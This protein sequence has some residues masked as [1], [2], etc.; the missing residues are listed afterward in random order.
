MDARERLL[1]AMAGGKPDRVPVF[2]SAYWDYWVRSVGANLFDYAYGDLDVQVDIEVR[3]ARRH[4]GVGL[5]RTAGLNH[6]PAPPS[7]PRPAHLPQSGPPPWTELIESHLPHMVQWDEAPDDFVRDVADI[8]RVLAADH[9]SLNIGPDATHLRAVAGALHDDAVIACGGF[10]LFPHTRRALGGVERT[11]FALAENPGLVEATMDALLERYI[12]MIASAA[13]AGADAIWAGAYNE[14]GDMIS[15]RMWRRL[16]GP[17]HEQLVQIAH[18]AGLKAICWFLGDC[19][20][21]VEDLARVGYDMLVIEESRIGYR[22]DVGEMRRRVGTD[23][24]LS[25]WVPELAMLYDDRDAIARHVEE[26]YEA[27]GRDGA[28]IFSTSML[29]SSVDP[30]TVDFFCQKVLEC[31]T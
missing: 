19:L 25:G 4:A 6:I 5:H 22:S 17:R 2:V 11:M 7:P 21:L 3:A 31:Q 20:P 15:P 16:I 14:G 1:C 24:C 23:L 26:Q 28:F 9:L 18:A 8:P 30:D 29:D 12:P 10:G 13:A 27:A